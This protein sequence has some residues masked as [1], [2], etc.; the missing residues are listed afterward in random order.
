MKPL[1]RFLILLL[2]FSLNSGFAYVI[3][4]TSSSGWNEVRWRPAPAT[5]N[6]RM[7]QNEP[8]SACSTGLK[9]AH[10]SWENEARSN[11]DYTYRGETSTNTIT[12]DTLNI[13]C[14][15]NWGTGGG[16]LAACYTWYGTGTGTITGFD[17]GLNLDFSWSYSGNPGP[18]Q[19]DFQSTMT[20]EFGH[21]L[22]LADLYGT[23]DKEKTMYG[24]GTLGST[25]Q[26]TLEQDDKDGIAYLYPTDA[27]DRVWIRTATNDDGKAPYSGVFWQSPDI[28]LKPN[29]PVLS[30]PCTIYVTGR[31]MRPV[32]QTTRL[33]I[34]IH[35][36][37]VC[38]QARKSVMYGCTLTNKIIPPGNRDNN[39]DGSADYANAKGCGETTYRFIWTP[40]PN[41]FGED[42]YCCIATVE[43]IGS[44]TV[45]D[46][47]IPDDNDVACRNFWTKKGGKDKTPVTM[48]VDAGNYFEEPVRRHL[49]LDTTELPRDWHAEI[50]PP[51]TSR[52]LNPGDTFPFIP[53]IPI[54]IIPASSAER[55]D[56][57]IVHLS[58]I[59]NHYT[60]E[61]SVLLIGGGSFKAIVGEPGD[62]GTAEIL[63]PI[64]TI[65]TGRVTPRAIVKN[66]GTT[67]ETLSVRFKIGDTYSDDTSNIILAPDESKEIAFTP[68]PATYGN[69][70]VSCSTE[71]TKDWKTDND[72]LT[73]EITVAPPN[74][75]SKIKDVENQPSRKKVKGGGGITAVGNNLYL[76]LGNNTLDFLR[77]SISDNSWTALESIP[78][79]PKRKR[80]KK[81]AYIIDDE[82]VADQEHYIYCLKGGGTNE[83]YR[84]NP[85]EDKWDSLPQPDFRK[86]VKG[87]FASF[88][89]LGSERY[90]YAGSGSNNS[91]WKRYKISTGIWETPSPDSLPV[92]K[93]KVGSG[94]TSDGAGKIYFLQDGGKKNYFWYADLNA[95]APTWIK[96]ESLPLRKPNGKNKKVKEGGCIEYYQGKIY[97]VKGG[98]TKEFWSY[99]PSGDTWHY[100]GEIGG[101]AQ[102]KGI[103][104]GRSLTSTTGGIYCLIGNNTNELWFYTPTKTF[105]TALAPAITGGAV[106]LQE[107]RLKVQPNPT[108]G[109]AQIYYTLPT[110][111]V[112]TLKIYNCLGEIVYNAKSDK[113][114]FTIRKLPAGIYILRFSTP[115]YK[116][117]KKLIVVK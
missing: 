95:K 61:D 27:V 69:Y 66:F 115:T 26:R 85:V 53:P 82:P 71:L 42:H 103:K 96:I 49:F 33:I 67:T 116:E 51:E 56:Y 80:V 110:K 3:W 60:V 113:G 9:A 117:D 18:N 83:F 4:R 23:A 7:N 62:V 20:H 106:N 50:P 68:W 99:D 79:G 46:K 43:V 22:D 17:I 11:F 105:V 73:T 94:L 90:I 114:L 21:T 28:L 12:N 91:Q 89:E 13:I 35:D 88:V 104:C 41:K 15:K 63:A 93:A 58:C 102:G 108:K 29:P 47:D 1:K 45:R 81:G 8:N 72:Q 75:W 59:L 32:N 44:D 86:G 111:Q 76:I 74:A 112:A 14:W 30:K 16:I 65:D 25:K 98:N 70:L 54:T 77:Y 39:N 5:V 92:L 40:N 52:I 38:L 97:G 36:P 31:N 10:Q 48:Q 107:S 64:G 19:Y 2:L 84:Y 78:K 57:G 109:I 87:G 6:Y 37:D 101:A 55:G 24:Y 100:I 34:E